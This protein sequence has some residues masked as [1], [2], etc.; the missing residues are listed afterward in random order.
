MTDPT[1][2]ETVTATLQEPKAPAR[3]SYRRKRPEDVMEPESPV[4]R[5]SNVVFQA[6][7]ASIA[8]V[9]AKTGVG[10]EAT[11]SWGRAVDQAHAATGA[12]TTLRME[13]PV[14]IIGAGRELLSNVLRA[15]PNFNVGPETTLLAE[16]TKSI[17]TNRDRLAHEGYPEQYWYKKV[18]DEFSGLQAHRASQANKRRWVEILDTASIPLSTLDRMFPTSRIVNVVT[19]GWSRRGV[20]G[21]RSSAARL[22]AGRYLEVRASD[23]KTN[24]DGVRRQV[25][26][27][28]GE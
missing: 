25:L 7:P 11:L 24:P 17:E 4:Q 10:S 22:A 23:L 8:G 5:P 6:S 19:D 16:M 1:K 26:A 2:N 13:V 12:S 3:P 15:H 20:R 9:L 18:A 27:F 21:T 14:F 28:L